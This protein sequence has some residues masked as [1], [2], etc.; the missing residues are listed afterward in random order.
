MIGTP[1]VTHDTHRPH[2]RDT[3]DT[4][5]Q[6]QGDDIY[7]NRDIKAGAGTLDHTWLPTKIAL[8]Q[9][10]RCTT[11]SMH[12]SH[13]RD[14][15]LYRSQGPIKKKLLLLINRKPQRYSADK[16]PHARDAASCFAGGRQACIELQPAG[17]STRPALL[18]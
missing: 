15:Q 7:R 17:C 1:R 6:Q 5:A 4:A 9:Q 12:I 14:P 8:Q 11:C 16:L 18:I 2:A 13:I 3:R 10:C